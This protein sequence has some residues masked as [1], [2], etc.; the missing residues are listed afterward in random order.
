M[1]GNIL[2]KEEVCVAITTMCE[3]KIR[4]TENDDKHELIEK[5]TLQY[6]ESGNELWS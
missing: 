3:N 1:K 2:T 6:I 4:F 5:L